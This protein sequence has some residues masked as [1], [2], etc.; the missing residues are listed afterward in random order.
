MRLLFLVLFVFPA[1]LL[2]Q[3]NINQM[4]AQGKRHGIWK[5]MYPNTKQLR[6]E[7]QFE[8]G[9]E[10][11]TF[12]FYCDACR[13]VPTVIKEFNAANAIAKVK[14]FT[15]KSQLVSEGGMDGKLRIGEWVYY[16]KKGNS[17]MTRESY[18]NGEIS[19]AKITYYPNGEVAEELN[20][21]NGKMNG[22][23]KYFAPNGT[24]LK[25]LIYANNK[26]DGNAIYFDERGQKSIE[27]VYRDDKK[28]GVWKYY[29]N[30]KFH[31]DET[32]PKPRKK[33][34]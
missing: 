8:H 6:Y 29:K 15:K 33:A 12:K 26:L 24:L 5:K 23:N 27:G 17:I 1:I 10:V 19:G 28:H 4:D 32:F 34:N 31:H 2:A 22:T 9:K 14:Y 25:D 16:H 18:S 7:G 3:G 21:L 13:N 20:F 11:G 30:G